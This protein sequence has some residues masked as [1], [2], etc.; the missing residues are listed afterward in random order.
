M[1]PIRQAGTKSTFLYNLTKKHNIEFKWVKAHA[2]I[3]G[4][5][6]ADALANEAMDEIKLK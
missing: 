1:H 5:E 2:N 4:N 6:R 3:Y